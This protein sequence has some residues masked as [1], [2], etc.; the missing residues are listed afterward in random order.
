M[1]M[2][3]QRES[4]PEERKTQPYLQWESHGGE[5]IWRPEQCRSL[6]RRA[7]GNAAKSTRAW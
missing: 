7:S 1:R 4:A 2:R 3:K 5:P 6:T